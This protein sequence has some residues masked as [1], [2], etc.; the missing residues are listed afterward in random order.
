MKIYSKITL[1]IL[2]TKLHVKMV[3][4][5]ILKHALGNLADTYC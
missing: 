4:T 2:T 1:K 5:Y 3:P